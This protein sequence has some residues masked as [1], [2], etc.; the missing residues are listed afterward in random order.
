MVHCCDDEEVVLMS[1]EYYFI[2]ITIMDQCSEYSEYL[3]KPKTSL[4]THWP[5]FDQI[6]NFFTIHVLN[7]NSEMIVKNILATAGTNIAVFP[8]SWRKSC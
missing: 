4:V 5:F 8:L 6:N 7:L 1:I 3:T 2:D